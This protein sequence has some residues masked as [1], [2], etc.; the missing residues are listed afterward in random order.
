MKEFALTTGAALAADDTPTPR[1]PDSFAQLPLHLLVASLTNPRKTF[2]RARLDE[3]VASVKASG[4]H[5]PILV[6]PLPGSRIEE[7]SWVAVHPQSVSPFPVKK[8]ERPTH[9][10]VA[11]ERRYRASIEAGLPTIPAMIR[12]LTDA[13]VLETQLVE[14]LQRD[15]L[16]ELE[17]A[18]GYERLMAHSQLTAEAVGSKIGKSRSYVYGRLKLLD[19]CQEA[20]QALREGAIDA[21]RALLIAR[22]P[23]GKLQI[24]AVAYASEAHSGEV[25]SVRLLQTWLRQNVMLPL[26]RAPFQIAD[27]RLVKV[28]GSCKDCP[29]RTGASPDL[30][31]D[32]L[33][34]DI[35]TDPPCYNTKA[36]AHL[37]ALQARADKKGLRLIAGSEA[38]SICYEK[39][40]T[41]NGYSPLSQV[42]ADAG[43]QRLDELLGKAPEGAVLIENPWTHELIEAVQ[44]EEAEGLLLAKGLVKSIEVPVKESQ[45]TAASYAADVQ[46]IKASTEGRIENRY[47]DLL[48]VCA[49]RAIIDTDDDEALYLIDHTVLLAHFGRKMG[50]ADGDQALED[51]GLD[52]VAPESLTRVQ[53]YKFAALFMALGEVPVQEAIAKLNGIHLGRLREDAKEQVKTEVAAEIAALKKPAKPTTP[54]AQPPATPAADAKTKKPAPL[55]KPKLSAQDAQSG[56]A[57]AMQGLEASAVAAESGD[58]DTTLLDRALQA[59]MA[60]DRVSISNVQRVLRVGYNT[61]AKLLEALELRGDLSPMDSTGRRA[62]LRPAPQADQPFAIG[63]RV[64]V[65]DDITIQ[66]R[67]R[68][69]GKTGTIT[70]YQEGEL[71]WTVTFKGRTGGVGVFAAGEIEVV[72]P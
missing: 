55:R 3:L 15:D 42:R 39:S 57:E 30:F 31:A 69:A 64:R 18:E 23:D 25:P 21:S 20:K 9:E 29:K 40:S 34:A 28:A 2:N 49:R 32:V 10:V 45:N 4:V 67:Q 50:Y 46:K 53:I 62:L 63:Q 35:C 17:E 68:F 56:I 33:G 6:R 1:E 11:G 60:S 26:D 22:I 54:L 13:Q 43:G 37:A 36:A 48:E 41:L 70:G 16:T 38:K 12:H 65:I 71:D 72:Q 5:Q 14:N 7:T 8:A 19:L 47:E 24:K 52:N 51:L 58:V 44:T 66:T 61:A 59:V 27:A